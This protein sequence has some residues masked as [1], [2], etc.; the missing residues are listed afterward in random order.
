[1]KLKRSQLG[2]LFIVA[3]AIAYSL[4]EPGV[5]LLASLLPLIIIFVSVV[6]TGII[7]VG[8]LFNLIY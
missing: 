5:R 1:M 2:L 7:I 8:Y 4:L 3:W 6:A